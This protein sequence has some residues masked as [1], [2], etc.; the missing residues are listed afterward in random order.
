LTWL[1]SKKEKKEL[2]AL[3]EGK[4]GRKLEATSSTWAKREK[5]TTN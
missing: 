2:L 5:D 1:F 4:R 3:K